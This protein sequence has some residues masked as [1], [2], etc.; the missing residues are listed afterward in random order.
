MRHCL[1]KSPEERFQSARDL[2]FHLESAA[3]VA[4]TGTAA[5]TLFQ[6]EKA[7]RPLWWMIALLGLAL[8]GGVAWWFRGRPQPGPKVV[9]S[10]RLTD[11][12]GLEESPAFSP[13]GKSFVCDS[14]ETRQIWIRLLAGG[15]HSKLRGARVCISSPGGR[16]TRPPLLLHSTCRRSRARCSMGSVGAGWCSPAAGFQH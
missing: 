11:Y 7:V 10:L 8:A 15:L 1:E 2:T 5:P 9:K 12:A 6:Q 16:R 14:T 4:E 3:S 13:D